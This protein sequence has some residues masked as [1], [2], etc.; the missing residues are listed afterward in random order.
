MSAPIPTFQS[1]NTP[2]SSHALAQF[3]ADFFSFFESDVKVASKDGQ[4]GPKRAAQKTMDAA[5][6]PIHVTLAPELGAYFGHDELHLVFRHQDVA[7]NTE[8]VAAGSRIFDRMIN[9]LAQRAAL[10]VQRAPSRHVGGEELLR[11]VR[12]V[13][14]SIAKLNMQQVMQLLYIYNWRI[15]YRADDKREELYTVVLDENGN[16]VLLQGEPGAAADAPMLATLLADVQ[17]VALVQ[18]D[19]AAA[20]ALRLPPMTQLTRLAETARKYAIYH[21]DVRCVTHEAEI[22]PRLYKVLNRLHGYYSQQIEDVYDSHDPTGEKRRALEDDLQRKLAEEVENHRLRVGVELVSYAIIQMPV[23]TADVTLSDGKQ[24][25]AVSVA[26]N[27]YTGELQRAR[28]H[29]CHKEMSTIALDR[30]GH[31]M[32]D[33]CLFQCAACLDLLCATC[34]VA[35]CP[36]CQKENCDRC[37]HECWACGERACAEH[38]SRCPVC[39]DDVCHA[40]QTECAQCGA[41]QCRS[42]L[43][44]DCVT[45]AAGSPELICASCAVR[46]AGCNQYS[47]HFDVCDASG[48]RFCLNCLKTCADC[49]R[50]V[51]PGFY[52]AAAGD[53]GV[54]CANCITL[55]PG[56]SASAVN[57]RYC[58]TCGAAHCAN[59]G[60]TCDTCKKHFC[61]QHAARDRVCKHVF[62]REHG[63]ACGVCGDPLCAACNATCGICERYYCIAH[64]A[65][66]ELCRCTYCRECV[67]SSINLCDT[68]ATIQNEGEQVDLADEPIAAHPDVQS[69]IE[70]HVWLRGVN[71]NYTIYLGL[72]SHNMGALV[73]VEND[74]P[75][76]EILVVRK[77]HAVDLYW[78][79][80]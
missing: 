2:N 33:D 26:R 13:N 22:Q 61:H 5:P 56:C 66:C 38:I 23:A 54:Y 42:H 58:E 11:A 44:A 68:C 53:R 30:N 78:K 73:L 36:V 69:L 55:C 10:T 76:G 64:N 8:L 39:Q 47:A 15:V 79:K 77:L 12:P 35:V 70:R 71:M 34:G 27:L 18:G 14:T 3:A 40:C 59:C 63:A 17:P 48:Q 24:E 74:A 46:C 1:Y 37:S 51:G 43:R 72:A 67:R 21:A 49:G 80:F 19:D 41:R 32:C 25:A 62:C 75:A 45:P 16:R 6:A 57:I 7:S 50:K 31:L 65:V 4:A 60:H 20:D 28:C 29:A 9:Y 52:H